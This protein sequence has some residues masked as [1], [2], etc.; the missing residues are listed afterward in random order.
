DAGERR[1]EFLRESVAELGIG[2]R[3]QVVRG[4]AEEVG[5]DPALRGSMDAVVARSVGPPPVTAEGRAPLV[6]V[7]GRVV[8]R[9]PPAA[10]ER[11]DAD[12]WPSDGVRHVGLVEDE[13]W[14]TPYRFRSFVLAEPCPDTYPRR[15]GI[16]AKRP[17]F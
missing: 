6:R 5:R 9:E 13:S 15:V 3:V 8:V 10:A 14:A 11:P 16:P 7:A 12:R 2:D 4:R 1:C 17:L